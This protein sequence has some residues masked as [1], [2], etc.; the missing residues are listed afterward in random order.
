MK[1][2]PHSLAGFIRF[3]NRKSLR[4]RTLGSYLSWV[5]RIARHFGVACPSQLPRWVPDIRGVGNGQAA[6]R[7]LARYVNKTAL[8]EQR[9]LGYDRAG[10]L[11]LNC[12]SS[13]TGEWRAITL[14]PAEPSADGSR[15]TDSP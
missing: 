12:Q 1:D 9:L 14:T 13:A 4:A 2:I 15:E 10:N 7:Y 6:V 5:T 11:R 3:I 8:S